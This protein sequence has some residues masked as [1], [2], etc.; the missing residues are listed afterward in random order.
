MRILLPVSILVS[1]SF[2]GVGIWQS[3]WVAI[4]AGV[5]LL[6]VAITAEL[7]IRRHRRESTNDNQDAK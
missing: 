5:G 4:T 6:A 2:V 7:D 1:I 3:A